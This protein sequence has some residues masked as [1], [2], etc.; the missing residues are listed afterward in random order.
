MMAKGYADAFLFLG[1][2]EYL[3]TAV[4][5]AEFLFEKASKPDG[6]LY[7][8]ISTK[9]KP[10]NGFLE[11]YAQV[12]D[13]LWHLY[14]ATF[15]ERYLQKALELADYAIRHFHD[16]ET[17]MFFFTSDLDPALVA[18]KTE[19][20]DSVIPSS[21]S[22]M[23]RSLRQLGIAFDREDLKQISMK[24]L[25]NIHRSYTQRPT[26]YMNWASLG[27]ESIQEEKV[28]AVI[29]PDYQEKIV[30]LR[31]LHLPGIIYFGAGGPSELPYLQN[32]FVDGMTLIY[33]C[34]GKECKMPVEN[35]VEVLSF[36][37]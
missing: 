24:M 19:T 16:P 21:N 28:M 3:R 34:T 26:S 14:Q 4:R 20:Y 5:N 15:E 2:P 30:A 25:K 1:H 31:K 13:L 18:R 33:F 10:V 35:P 9:S 27:L 36:I 29:G 7:H 32:R 23:A 11:D 6:G 22:V 12:I 8:T 17:G 37:S